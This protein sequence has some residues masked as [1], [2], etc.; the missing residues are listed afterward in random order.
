M[1]IEKW[2]NWGKIKALAE[3][4]IKCTETFKLLGSMVPEKIIFKNESKQIELSHDKIGKEFLS[5][6][7]MEFVKSL[8]NSIVKIDAELKEL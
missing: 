3:T 1:K 2:E 6:A 7:H 5:Y 4:R 8:M